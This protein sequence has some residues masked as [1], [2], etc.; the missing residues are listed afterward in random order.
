MKV[1]IM[2][3]F[4]FNRQNHVNL[5][6]DWKLF[7]ELFHTIG[8]FTYK[9]NIQTAFFDENSQRIMGVNK[10]MPGE[11]YQNLLDQLMAEPIKG[12]MNLYTA[13]IGAETRCIKLIVTRRSNEEI[14]FVEEWCRRPIHRRAGEEDAFDDMTGLLRL[15]SFSHIVQQKMQER[16]KI[17]L[18]ALHIKGLDR[19]SDF[20]A[21]NSRNYC[22]ASV[23]DVLGRF[24]S[25]KIL[26]TEK[27]FQEF[28]ACFLD[29][30]EKTVYQSLEQMREAVNNCILSDDFGLE[31]KTE[32]AIS[33]ELHAGFAAYPDNSSTIRGLCTCAEFALFETLH[34]N[35]NPVALFSEEEF[36]RK[37]DEYREEQLFFQIISQNQLT[38]HFQPIV[39]AHTGNI[40]GYEAL[41][42]SEH[43]RPDKLLEIAEK[44]GRLYDIERATLFNCMRFLSAHQNHFS[45]RLLFINCIPAMLLTESD[46]GEL[47]LMYEELFDKV[48]IE[49]TEQSEGSAEMLK[50]LKD[51]CHLIG[52]RLAIDDYGSGY[53]NTATL[54][55]NKPDFVK[56]DRVLLDGICKSTQKQQLVAGIIDYAHN[57]QI[58]VLA[59]GVEEEADLRTL[60]RMG[61]DLFQ[62]Y[63]TARPTPY[64]LE[65]IPN[66]VRDIIIN[67]N[68]ENE[69]CQRKI[70][71]AH[72]DAE[73]NLVELALHG[74]TDLHI[75]RSQLTVT[76]DPEKTVPMHIALMDNHSCEL[77]L[78]NVNIICKEKPTISV[79]SYA[80]LTVVA[81]GENTLSHN[82]IRVPEG[83]YFCLNGSGSLK[84][85]SY[86][87]FGC[88]I[89]GDCNS[90]YGCIFIDMDGRAELIC[91][92]DRGIAIGGGTNPD[93]SDITLNKGDIHIQVGSPNAVGIGS[94][95]GNAMI[96]AERGCKL[97]VE[98]N[99]ISSVGIG[100]LVGSVNIRCDADV[101]FSGSGN[102]VIGIGAL[103][104]GTGEITTTDAKMDFFMRT[105]FGTCIGALGGDV[106]VT[107]QGCRI[108]VDAEGSE[109]T[110][111]GD[112]KGSGD[113]TLDHTEVKACI[114]AAKPREAGSRSGQ[115]NMRSSTIN[116][117]INDR[118][119]TEE[120]E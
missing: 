47:R 56:I 89:G 18:A 19:A 71:N 27:A 60:I 5:S 44:Q 6:N 76:S 88:C 48:V 39:D 36:G 40:V 95:E 96:C 30:D 49:I 24:A 57:N 120:S 70:Y 50:T 7:S 52:A 23:A 66:D 31:L 21:T 29:T 64:L 58:T 38:Y 80:H 104:K 41:M 111:V 79:G 33:L 74:Y 67:T 90:S 59:E 32:D 106:T 22:M 20:S 65:E 112:A 86:T 117:D 37:K 91:N 105:N 25:D 14:G 9:E 69:S 73:I 61:A 107:A 82:G 34:D 46:F 68:L 63:F 72:N 8:A 3:I 11:E 83:A 110:G 4:R 1:F 103:A 109:I 54:L 10:T 85:D 42:R 92:S 78:R 87:K 45:S 75:Y 53:A 99:G 114:L 16:N 101:H 94:F 28:Y 102:K 26:F 51:R 55:R 100:A 77:T 35:Q 2:A 17:Y 13:H 15:S 108:E 97:S 118:H 113:V 81:E 43:F 98:T 62:G 119:N 115:L 12:E 116:A 93:D 84:V